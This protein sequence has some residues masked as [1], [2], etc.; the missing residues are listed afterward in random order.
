M[1]NFNFNNPFPVLETER[2]ILRRVRNSD[3]QEMFEI[4]SNRETMQYIPRPLA[5]T[6]EDAEKVID[7]INGF[8]ERN[9]RIN[10]AITEKGV[11]KMMGVIGYV[12]M[13]EDAH[14]S[15]VGYVMHHAYLRKGFAAE[16]L[17][18]V[19]KYGFE[20]MNLH[21]IEAII[22]PDNN[23]SINLV[24]RFGFVREA[25]FKDYVFHQK[26]YFDEAVYSLIDPSYNKK[27]G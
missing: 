26:Q 14:R 10:W 16:A 5:N 17:E 19:I 25:L 11:D 24:E 15:E 1:L 6:V 8:V 7:M 23:A 13:N 3:R 12:R 2:L 18:A 21:S 9:E 27:R 4:R 22:R 20:V